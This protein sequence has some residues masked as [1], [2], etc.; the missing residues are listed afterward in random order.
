MELILAAI[1]GIAV[2]SLAVYAIM[3][4][5][6]S[7]TLSLLENERAERRASTEACEARLAAAKSETEI[8]VSRAKV[9]ADAALATM[10]SESQ[11][12]L[13]KA[14]AE[15]DAALVEAKAD[16]RKQ[17][18]ETRHEAEKRRV[19]DLAELAE[20]YKMQLNLFREEL[21]NTTE[22]MLKERSRELQTNNATQLDTLFKPVRENIE[23]M[24]QSIRENRETAVKNQSSLEATIRQ[25]HTQTLNLGQQADRL[26]NALSRQNKIAG[27]WGELILTE[28]LE[29]QG[30]QQGVHFDVQSTLRGS[31]GN[32]L[33]HEET[34]SRLVPDVVLHLA[35]NRDLII[36]S[37]MSL[38]A[39]IDYQNA[40]DETARI[41]ALSRHI[42]SVK[43]HVRE[44]SAKR[45]NDYV[46]KPRVSADFVL[47]FVPIEG[48]LQLALSA[49]PELW[50]DAFEKKVFIVGGQTLIAA[51]RIIDLT[52][53]NVRQERNT[54]KIMDEAAKLIDRVNQFYDR[55]RAVGDR[56]RDAVAAYDSVTDK[57]K[58]GKQSILL[59]GRNLEALGARGKKSLPSEF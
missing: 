32:T 34:G 58:D 17:L 19:A 20:S 31:E 49:S 36:D 15:A 2:G 8:A 14:K 22:N 53:V 50:R 9:E 54:Q 27:N 26:S 33:H 10:K 16:A 41:E 37:K 4:A 56:L 28:I 12:A 25:M 35:D 29:S 43:S 39:F 51:L 3:R 47:M 44:L 42:E 13:D 1:I 48:A 38:T 5:R 30:L 59:A 21:K 11:A 45:Y 18:E 40:E 24:Q 7:A 23:Q 6:N 46:S 57:V 52:W 55:F